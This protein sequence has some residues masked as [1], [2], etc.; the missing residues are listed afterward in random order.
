MKNTIRNVL[1]AG[2]MM[3]CCSIGKAQIIYSN[4]FSLGTSVNIS[5]TPPTIANTYAGG[6]N[7]AAWIDVLGTNDTGA[8]L[9]N[10]VDSCTNLGDS[11]L[12][13]FIPQS[14]YIYLLTANVTFTNNPGN[15]LG[16]GFCQNFNTNVPVGYARFSDSGN[17]GPTGYNWMILTETTGNVQYFGGSKAANTIY[18]AN[19]AFP[20]G[21]GT[22]TVWIVLNT[23]V[24]PWAVAGYVDGVAMG[25]GFTYSSNPTIHG[26]GFT[27][28][29]MTAPTCVQ[30]N[31]FS[32][33][34]TLQPFITRQPESGSVS[35]GS[36]YTNS[37]VVTADTNGGPLSYQWYANGAPLSNGGVFSGVNTN[38][39][40]INPATT[41]DELTNYYVVVNNA[42]GS[43]TSSLA[44][45]T[46]YT[47]P[48]VTEEFPSTYTNLI[49]LF[50]GTGSYVGSSPTFSVSTVGAQPLMYQWLTNGVALG[51]ATNA[52]LT[53]TNCQFDGPTNFTCV[54]SNIF[55]AVS[56][57]WP[58]VYAPT[59]VAPY[60]QSVLAAQPVAFW[61]LNE[62]SGT[63]CE[64]YQNGHDGI[65]TNVT[66]AQTG[67]NS[68]EPTET[69]VL[70]GN[71]GIDNS[72][73]G[74]ISNLDFAEPAGSNA[75]FTVEAWV[76][77]PTADS[78]APIIIKGAYGISD[79]FGLGA[80][81]NTTRHFQFYV[82]SAAGTVYK[83]DSTFALDGNW[84]HLVG[85]CDESNGLVSL[86]ID[87]ALAAST[88]IPAGS[89]EYE[90]TAPIAIGAATQNTSSGYDL[91]FFGYI[92]DV[93]AYNYALSPIQ[94]AQQYAT[95]GG[96]LFPEFAPPPPSNVTA[97]YGGTAVIPGAVIGTP[98]IGYY[99]TNTVT[100]TVLASG[101]TNVLAYLNTEVTIPNASAG[102]NGEVLELV[103]TNASGSTNWFTTLY[104]VPPPA[105]LGYTNS[106]LYTNQ[107][108]A[109]PVNIAGLPVTAAN[110]L[111]G[112]TNTTWTDALGTNDT[113][114]MLANGVDDSTMPDS[115]VLPFTPHSGYI[116]TLNAS[117]TFTG[118]AS[119]WVGLGFAQRVPLNAAVGYGR[120]SDGGTTAPDLGPN[121]YDWLILTESSGNVQAFG[122]PGGQKQTVNQD[123]FTAGPGTHN[124]QITLDTTGAQW[125][126]N[127]YVDG[128]QATTNYTYA[129]GTNPP[130]GA[131]GITQNSLSSTGV[132][133]WNYLTLSQVAP[134]GV[135]PYL[136]APLPTSSI[137][138]TNQTVTL[139]ATAFGS[140]PLGYY[141]INNSTVIASGTTNAMAPLPAD[142]SL[143]SAAL[144]AGQL[145]LVVTNAYGTNITSVSLVSPINPSPTNIVATVTNSTLYLTWPMDHTGWQLQAQ[146]NSLGV[147]LGTNWA[148]YNPSTGTNQVAIPI[149]LTNGAVFY[150][151]IYSP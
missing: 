127:A 91:Q 104:T 113:G 20:P 67:Y 111:V 38:V 95:V 62:S 121:G 149:N 120:F 105:T 110:S 24:S 150:R 98:P 125:V 86:Y 101:S 40:V 35:S 142:L 124:V 41:A 64:D 90:T 75:E 148:N 136:L 6:T 118:A 66:L 76:Q 144:S 15:W 57:S 87:G 103:V 13:P 14:G 32:L 130:I 28:N 117:L 141:W 63:L 17:D 71:G 106:V 45:L 50:G 92:D 25:N 59:P 33:S 44:S 131:V 5:N 112:G 109:G 39:L 56:N 11:F 68:A 22:H 89:G 61:R 115:W 135:P 138:L 1:L 143:S 80:D 72:Y 102:M 2:V 77:S 53:Y 140:G 129:L 88:S 133:Q 116:Y 83:A 96:N 107:F 46:V 42:Y 36:P 146:T 4:N 10:G 81:T 30:L 114:S 31:T 73:V 51:G 54:V 122:G 78:G 3:F 37:V 93:A 128:F 79:A 123:I 134:G 147:G 9:A 139:P 16:V 49:T 21:P 52:S 7:T 82:R 137:V 26:V 151:L 94:V 108:D 55:G 18:S 47:N 27:Q 12:L 48:I 70:F 119:S 97:Y 145:D 65:Y 29:S 99:W 19:S 60:P 74:G 69:S 34:T 132:V 85:V 23:K 126:M 58:V 100:G 8:L 84:H 43:A